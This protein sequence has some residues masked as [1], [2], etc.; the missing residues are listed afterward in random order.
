[1]RDMSMGSRTGH[2]TMKDLR[3]WYLA[4]QLTGEIVYN[5]RTVLGLNKCSGYR[6]DDNDTKSVWKL[7][8]LWGDDP[9]MDSPVRYY[10][11]VGE[12]NGDTSETVRPGEKSPDFG[13]KD[14]L[15]ILQTKDQSLMM[16]ENSRVICVDATHGTTA[17]GYYLLSFVV[18]D[19]HGHALVVGWGITNKEN[20]RTWELTAKN[21]RKPA[22]D[23][24]PE[25]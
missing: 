8:N 4:T 2:K 12:T 22:R 10:K 3:L 7:V 11:P 16:K 13:K 1:M 24:N 19:R 25:V 14:F 17:Y 23:C 18:I 15:L 9:N 6:M 20:H 5:R 21:L